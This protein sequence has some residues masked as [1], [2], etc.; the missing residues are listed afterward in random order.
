MPLLL[1]GAASVLGWE[2]FV[3]GDD[4]SA[5]SWSTILKIGA[6]AGAAYLA[7]RALKAVR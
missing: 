1:I 5:L 4:Q 2:L 3:R 6:V 7:A